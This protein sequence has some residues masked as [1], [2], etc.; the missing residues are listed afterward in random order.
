MPTTRS[1]AAPNNSCLAISTQM[2]PVASI[3]DVRPDREDQE[4]LVI[5]INPADIFPA[6]NA[7]T[8][9]DSG[10]EMDCDTAEDA[11]QSN[12]SGGDSIYFSEDSAPSS[13]DTLDRAFD[14]EME[15][16]LS[17]SEEEPEVNNNQEIII[18]NALPELGEYIEESDEEE[19]SDEEPEYLGRVVRS[20]S[21]TRILTI[22][23]TTYPPV[24]PVRRAV[25]HL[26]SSANPVLY[27]QTSY[28]SF[29]G[30][31]TSDPTD[32]SRPRV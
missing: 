4:E 16:D 27:F 29:I 7:D 13:Q 20:W 26:L 1:T 32:G 14:S 30:R 12:D 2:Q 11:D 10:T 18:N 3:S 15:P 21:P 31:A 8:E 17:S 19:S 22:R 9:G 5:R 25:R 23:D 6:E 24:V 28:P